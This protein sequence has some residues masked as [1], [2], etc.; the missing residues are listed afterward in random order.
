MRTQAFE[1]AYHLF[2]I[3]SVFIVLLCEGFYREIILQP[4]GAQSYKRK[5]QCNLLYAEI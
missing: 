2:E 5:F 3:I 1:L 4:G